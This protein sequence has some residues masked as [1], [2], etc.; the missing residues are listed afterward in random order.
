[1][2]QR[3]FSGTSGRT[4]SLEEIRHGGMGLA[5]KLVL[6]KKYSEAKQVLTKVLEISPDDA[7]IMT[8]LANIYLIEGKNKEAK[9]RLEKVLSIESN[10]PNAL[11]EMGVLYQKEG[12]HEKA[13]DMYEKAI[14]HYPEHEKDNI[15]DAYQNLGCAFWEVRRQEDALESWNTCLK[16][17]PRQKY[18][19]RNLKEFTNEYGM[20]R[21]PVGM[22]DSW[23]FVD[24]KMKEYLSAK[25]KS[26]F[27]DANESNAA[28]K[29]IM[30]AWNTQ[31]ASKY[32]RKLDQMKT[33]E[34]IKLFKEVKVF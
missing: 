12:E 32:G 18:A 17:N 10:Y 5:A 34:K 31:I 15:A 19:K 26:G 9:A 30:D 7:E 6:G 14:Q 22:D 20:A 3:R 24:M 27:D 2:K 4:L 16:Y 11:Y 8:L 28:L 29:K 13:I 1:M 25:G 23:A 21:S 33:K